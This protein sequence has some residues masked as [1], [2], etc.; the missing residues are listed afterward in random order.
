MLRP[1]SFLYLLYNFYRSESVQCITSQTYIRLDWTEKH[2]FG[3]NK[4][5][6]EYSIALNLGVTSRD[7]MW[8]HAGPVQC[9]SMCVSMCVEA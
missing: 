2:R 6:A 1:S 9:V 7:V 8:G 5:H 3:C 4:N